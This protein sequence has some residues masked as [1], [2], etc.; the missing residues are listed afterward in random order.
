MLILFF[1]AAPPSSPPLLLL[2]LLLLVFFPAA[3]AVPAFAPL[4]RDTWV[5]RDQGNVALPVEVYGECVYRASNGWV[6][7]ILP[8]ALDMSE[9]HYMH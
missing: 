4:L 8:L 1:P 2:L 6:G 3:A 9:S 5:P 7:G